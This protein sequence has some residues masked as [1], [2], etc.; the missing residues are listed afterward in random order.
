MKEVRSRN[1]SRTLCRE[2]ATDPVPRLRLIPLRVPIS[3]IAVL[4]RRGVRCRNRS[5][6]HLA[7]FWLVR[8][9]YFDAFHFGVLFG[10]QFSV[11]MVPNTGPYGVQRTR[12]NSPT[13]D[14]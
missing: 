9:H 13:K 8:F 10:L 12:I 1:H 6:F 2:C 14:L 11:A 3:A 5:S 7:P 4:V